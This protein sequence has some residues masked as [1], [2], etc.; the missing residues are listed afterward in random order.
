MK[1]YS[2]DCLAGDGSIY[3]CDVG[4]FGSEDAAIARAQ[5]LFDQHFE[6]FAVDVWLEG[7]LVA[8]LIRPPSKRSARL[9][10]KGGA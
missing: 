9:A 7:G 6:T 1:T 2:F 4:Q 5:A 10:A 3:T 8:R